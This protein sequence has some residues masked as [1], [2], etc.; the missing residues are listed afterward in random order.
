MQNR[1]LHI[2]EISKKFGISQRTLRYYEELSLIA[3]ARSD[4]GFRVFDQ[5]QEEK[6]KTILTLKELGMSLDDISNLIRLKCHGED[7]SKLTRPLLDHL[8]QRLDEFNN[9]IEKYKSTVKELKN[10][11]NIIEGCTHCHNV[12]EKATCKLCLE[13]KT[14]NNVPS[15]MKTLL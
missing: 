3:T 12:T 1:N 6:I 7:G 15:L 5:D 10:V 11:I 4:G 8:K 14:D 2:G 13:K 9:K